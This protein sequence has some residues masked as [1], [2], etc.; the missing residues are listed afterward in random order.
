MVQR[1]TAEAGPVSLSSGEQMQLPQDSR[2]EA[3]P[4]LAL[5]AAAVAHW[6]R[7]QEQQ[8]CQRHWQKASLEKSSD[9]SSVTRLG[10]WQME[11]SVRSLTH[12]GERN[13]RY[14]GLAKVV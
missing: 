12:P 2:R 8:Q 7:E 6:H 14:P 1:L 9:A 4:P 10:L 13:R 3:P 5:P 11:R